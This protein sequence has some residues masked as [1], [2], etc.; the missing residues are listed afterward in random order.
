MSENGAKPV[1]MKLLS[2]SLGGLKTPALPEDAEPVSAVVLVK[3]VES[4]GTIGWSV[5]TTPGLDD[6]EVLGVFTSYTAHLR[7]VAAA[8]WD[9]SE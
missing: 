3:L 1:S 7:Q 2:E 9:D 6:D 5:R 4:D 8:A